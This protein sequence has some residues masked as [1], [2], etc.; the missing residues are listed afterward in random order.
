MDSKACACH[1]NKGIKMLSVSLKGKEGRGK[2]FLSA[3]Q[4][5]YGTVCG[6]GE[7]HIPPPCNPNVLSILAYSWDGIASAMSALPLVSALPLRCI[8]TANSE[9]GV[10]WRPGKI[11]WTK[12]RGAVLEKHFFVGFLY[13]LQR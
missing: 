9:T 6:V 13:R 11:R 4:N 10:L 7:I 1:G 5:V 3:A 12:E 2:P 8:C